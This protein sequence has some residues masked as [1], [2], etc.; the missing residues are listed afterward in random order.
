MQNPPQQP[1]VLFYFKHNFMTE[2]GGAEIRT[3]TLLDYLRRVDIPFTVY[4]R[5]DGSIQWDAA[6]QNQFK[7]RYPDAQLVLEKQGFFGR[8]VTRI[9]NA[10]LLSFPQW[11]IAISRFRVIGM[12]RRYN[13]LRDHRVII[14]SYTDGVTELNGVDLNHTLVETH[15]LL[16]LHYLC[17]GLW[18][19]WTHRASSKY[20]KDCVVADHVFG[21]VAIQAFEAEFYRKVTRKTQVVCIPS[22]GHGQSVSIKPTGSDE[23]D[24]IFVGSLSQINS[25]GLCRFLQEFAGQLKS[26]RLLICG[27]ICGD[28]RVRHLASTMPNL[29]LAGFVDDLA[30]L[31]QKS[32]FAISPVK[33]TGLKIKI[34]TALKHSVP[35]IANHSSIQ[36]LPQGYTGCV[37]PESEL[38][39]LLLLPSEELR[40]LKQHATH[41]Y[42][43]FEA[44][45]KKEGL[46]NLI[47]ACA[48]SKR[49]N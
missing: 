46:V 11:A 30:P 41:Y 4:S 31:Y 3:L 22:Y 21:L 12:H 37:F 10:L 17:R 48:Y 32:R 8:T 15:D 25:A 23:Y 5:P 38:K 2:W 40:R 44:D 33:G 42:D 45:S 6:S 19:S 9:K 24:L 1:K 43:K 28:P 16:C 26:Y 34:V 27:E 7:D 18:P 39:R 36:G 14:A 29:T 13:R 47:Q 35:V 49:M 20:R